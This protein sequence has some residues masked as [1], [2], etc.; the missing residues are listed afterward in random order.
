[1]RKVALL[2][3]LFLV[4]NFTFSQ[5][6]IGT[7]TPDDSAILHLESTALGFLP[8]RMTSAQR[9]AILVTSNSK[10][11]LIYNTDSN[12]LN[13][14]DG[15]SW[16]VISPLP[17]TP[18]TNQI[19]DT[20]STYAE[21][22]TCIQTNYTPDQTLGYNDARDILY[23]V[24]DVNPSTQ[25]L[26]GIYSDYTILMD[27]STD[28]DASSH[29]FNLDIN[30][31]H[32]YPQSMGASNEPA[33]S[34]MFNLFPS[35]VAVNSDR[36]SC[37]FNDI[38]DSDTES[39]Y[40]LTQELSTIPGSNIDFYS[41]IDEDGTYPLLVTGQQCTIEP[42]ESKKGDIARVVFYF[43]AIYNATNINSY[44]SYANDD[45]FNYMKTTLLTWHINDPVDQIE[46]DRNTAIE[47]YQG[48][49]NPFVLDTT[50]AG[51]MFN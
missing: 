26:K 19:C 38:E 50:L 6:G 9:D 51:R 30:A 32:V 25:E 5:V 2:L 4:T 36:G 23:G 16:H 11:L 31:E 47:S 49:S 7:E 34:D 22:L 28:A 45:F 12:T 15:L 8:P 39:W 21:F 33:R 27:Y 17:T 29:A 13:I 18:V 40:Y 41:E 1:M 42:R 44:T 46:I 48:N 20:A 14:F 3:V 43:Y 35:R 24:V 10:G 37:V